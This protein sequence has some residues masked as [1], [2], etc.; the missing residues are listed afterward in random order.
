MRKNIVIIGCGESGSKSATKLSN[1]GH[2]VYIIDRDQNKLNSL[3]PSF[4]G[5]AINKEIQ[6]IYSIKNIT[7]V[8]ID[9]I[10]VVTENDNMNIFLSLLAKEILHVDKVITRLYNEKKSCIL[11]DYDVDIIYPSILSLNEINTYLEGKK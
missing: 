10:L 1:E 9:V 5:F 3:H 2:N 11:S 4:S 7:T 8:N 6:D